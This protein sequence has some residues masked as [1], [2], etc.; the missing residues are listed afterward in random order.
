VPGEEG[1]G[2][3]IAEKQAPMA[4]VVNW[5]GGELVCRKSRG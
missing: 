4:I 5:N 2:V 3:E 1:S